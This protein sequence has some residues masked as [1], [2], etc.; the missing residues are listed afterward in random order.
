MLDL[1]PR[2]P[3]TVRSVF[4]RPIYRDGGAR[5]TERK[6]VFRSVPR[7]TEEHSGTL[8]N[9]HPVPFSGDRT[10]FECSWR[11]F[12]SVPRDQLSRNTEQD[13]NTPARESEPPPRPLNTEGKTPVTYMI[14][15]GNLGHQLVLGAPLQ[16]DEGATDDR[17][18]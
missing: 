15:N 7:N 8:K 2:E 12:L 9:G 10:V 11:V 18:I 13:K 17:T 16:A 5:N 3:L 6:S 1:L 14:H 4:P